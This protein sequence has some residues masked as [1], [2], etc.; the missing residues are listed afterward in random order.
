M[1]VKGKAS[2]YSYRDNIGTDKYI[3]IKD[4][5]FTE[6][7]V[8]TFNT[9][10]SKGTSALGTDHVFRRTFAKAFYD[11]GEV[12]AKTKKL[13]F[14]LKQFIDITKA[15]NLCAEPRQEVFVN[16]P[17]APKF[18]IGLVAGTNFSFLTIKGGTSEVTTN[19]KYTSALNPVFGIAYGLNLNNINEK[20]SLK[21]SA[22]FSQTSFDRDFR[23]G[24]NKEFNP[25]LHASYSNLV[26]I[27]L[28]YLMVPL[29]VQYS[30][31]AGEIRPFFNAGI[32]GGVA[33]KQ[34]QKHTRTRTYKEFTTEEINP[35]FNSFGK[36]TQ[37][38]TVGAGVA[39]H[40]IPKHPILFE[41][42]FEFTDGF[43]SSQNIHTPLKTL[44]FT[45]GY[46]L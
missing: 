21:V 2:L 19:H 16:Q 20:L 23:D 32:V 39:F 37:G 24:E 35:V 26:Q 25:N 41:G 14:N 27:D 34:K 33:L 31:P 30:F 5:A 12:A 13:A 38:V 1:L 22:L 44:Y 15:Y 11:C 42:R 4:G 45:L 3:L 8:K 6:L 43:S 36:L 29:Q 18:K 46:Q 10:T 9:T 40:K 17:K 7:E 28:S